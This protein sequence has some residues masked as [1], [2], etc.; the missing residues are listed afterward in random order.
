MLEVKH[1]ESQV[2]LLGLFDSPECSEPW[3]PSYGRQTS[4][5]RPNEWVK[6]ADNVARN[7]AKNYLYRSR[8]HGE[9]LSSLYELRNNSF[10]APTMPHPFILHSLSCEPVPW[11]H[12]L[13]TDKQRTY[14]MNFKG[15]VPGRDSTQLRTV[16]FTVKDTR[17]EGCVTL[18]F[19]SKDWTQARG[20]HRSDHLRWQEIGTQARAD[21][22]GALMSPA[23]M[24]VPADFL[25]HK[26]PSPAPANYRW[27]NHIR[28]H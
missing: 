17:E 3:M 20:P 23:S 14:Q 1:A 12:G 19:S 22:M 26:P 24:H 16:Q 18:S 6:L 4:Y 7:F 28:F 21:R 15:N 8:P 13:T 11:A 5:G 10:S 9:S 27:V 25:R 2:V